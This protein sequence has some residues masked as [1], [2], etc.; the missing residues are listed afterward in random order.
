MASNPE[1]ELQALQEEFE[2]YTAISKET[3]D[4]LTMRVTELEGENAKLQRDL[5]A[6]REK[7]QESQASL[8]TA[9][10][11][12]TALKQTNAELVAE[13]QLLEVCIRS[14]GIFSSL[15]FIFC[16]RMEWVN[17]EI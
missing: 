15:G 4:E 3:E 6:S 14:T 12:L 2:E 1:A 8:G 5:G 16:I 7:A 11:E 17:K 9:L 13:K 10:D